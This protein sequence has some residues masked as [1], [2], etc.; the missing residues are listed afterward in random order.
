MYIDVWATWCGPCIAEFPKSKQLQKK[1]QNNSKVEFLYVSVDK[2]KEA[3][4]KM[5]ADDMNFK[6][7]H[8]IQIEGHGESIWESYQISGIP[9]YILIDQN[10]DIVSSD[11]AR[12]SS[13]E[14]EKEIN[15]L[16]LKGA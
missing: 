6:G 2:N 1:F 12:P 3:W 16:L 15:D 9:R 7:I 8:I 10:G 5:L 13:G 11:A 14:I 4:K